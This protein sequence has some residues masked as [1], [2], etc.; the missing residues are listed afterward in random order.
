VPVQRATFIERAEFIADVADAIEHRRGFA[1]GKIGF[2]EQRWLYDPI[3]RAKTRNSGQIR[4]Y[5]TMVKFDAE[6]QS[7]IFPASSDFLARFIPWHAG[8]I[9]T[10]DTLGLFR[11]PL[12]HEIFAHYGFAAKP[13]YY[14]DM[15]PDRSVPVRNEQCYLGTLAGKKLL[16]VAPFAELLRARA[17]AATFEAVWSNSGRRWFAPCSVA[18]IEFPY[19]FATCDHGGFATCIDLFDDIA[20]RM[21]RSDYD[22]ALIGAGCL[23]IP[24]AAHAKKTGRVGLSLGGHLQVMFGVIGKRWRE[25]KAWQRKHINAAWIDMPEI[26]HPPGKEFLADGG[27]Y[28]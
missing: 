6:R 15:Q 22:V 16:I 13:I 8:H 27:A 1:A 5:E 2:S 28:W 11:Y 7:G 10:V 3:L 14:G 18:A 23:G 26:Y 24:L 21:D 20:R 4:A 19:G 12:E 9:A 25:D 17:T